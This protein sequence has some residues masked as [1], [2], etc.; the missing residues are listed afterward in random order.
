M[1]IVLMRLHGVEFGGC[2]RRPVENNSQSLTAVNLERGSER[3]SWK[4]M[5]LVAAGMVLGSIVGFGLGGDV[6]S[7]MDAV[8]KNPTVS[9]QAFVYTAGGLIGGITGGIVAY[10]IATSRSL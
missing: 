7:I 1:Y 5:G 9:Y 4:K 6:G 3:F 10:C 8:A 2:G